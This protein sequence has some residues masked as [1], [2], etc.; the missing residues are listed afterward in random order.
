MKIPTRIVTRISNWTKNPQADSLRAPAR[1]PACGE[2]ARKPLGE[3]EKR[4]ADS[5][6]AAEAFSGKCAAAP[7]PAAARTIRSTAGVVK[8][9]SWVSQ[10]LQQ[11]EAASG[12]KVEER[13]VQ[14]QRAKAERQHRGSL[15]AL[16]LDG[17]TS[18]LQIPR[19]VGEEREEE[20]DAHQIVAA[21]GDVEV[22]GCPSEVRKSHASA[23]SRGSRA[24]A[25]TVKA[26]IA[27]TP[28]AKDERRPRWA[29]PARSNKLQARISPTWRA[30][31]ATSRR[32]SR[33]QSGE[34]RRRRGLTQDD[35]AKDHP[36]EHLRAGAGRLE[37][38]PELF[39]Q[40][41]LVVHGTAFLFF[42]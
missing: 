13:E 37:P 22:A 5:Q 12:D 15:R 4:G 11:L 10:P 36:E 39:V 7:R 23:R 34:R 35:Q 17:S 42:A 38:E 26:S 2:K 1:D 9:L 18:R 33:R 3:L 6:R 28:A 14:L 21:V 41:V 32:R 31:A 25:G 8:M 40:R 30:R 19:E 27:R 20:E 29:E 16:R 24:I